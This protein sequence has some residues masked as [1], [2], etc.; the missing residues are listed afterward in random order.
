[1]SPGERSS[2]LRTVDPE[3]IAAARA[4]G[5]HATIM[6][7][8]NKYQTVLGVS[9]VDLGNAEKHLLAAARKNYRVRRKLNRQRAVDALWNKKHG[10]KA[11]GEVPDFDALHAAWEGKLERA[12]REMRKLLTVPEVRIVQSLPPKML[13]AGVHGCATLGT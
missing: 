3:A 13:E 7:L 8:P 4:V 11:L 2:R 9:G 6:A 1:M 10:T 12:R 5:L